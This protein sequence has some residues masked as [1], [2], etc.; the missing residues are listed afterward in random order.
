[1]QAPTTVANVMTL[2]YMAK[3][4]LHNSDTHVNKT[5]SRPAAV[6][7]RSIARRFMGVQLPLLSSLGA[8]RRA[9]LKLHPHALLLLPPN[10]IAKAG[11]CQ[12]LRSEF[13]MHFIITRAVH[14]SSYTWCPAPALPLT[15]ACPPPDTH[16]LS[17]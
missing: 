14:N 4:Y 10:L 7:G 17:P 15:P 2:Q 6:N 5:V 8:A 3:M 16:L 9:Q 11:S 12:W 13:A 1:M